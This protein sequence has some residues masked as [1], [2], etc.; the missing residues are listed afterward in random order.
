VKIKEIWEPYYT[1]SII[2]MFRVRWAEKINTGM[3]N[4]TTMVIPPSTHV[5]E[6]NVIAIAPDRSHGYEL[7]IWDTASI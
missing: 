4:F 7:N 1:I 5:G 2:P 3:D 6:R